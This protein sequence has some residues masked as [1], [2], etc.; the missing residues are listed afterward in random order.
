[1]ASYTYWIIEGS[2]AEVDRHLHTD[3]KEPGDQVIT[4]KDT[5]LLK[6]GIGRWDGEDLN[7][8]TL[9]LLEQ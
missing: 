1:M 3:A 4:L 2:V 5:L 9:S 6:L 8:Y 7:K